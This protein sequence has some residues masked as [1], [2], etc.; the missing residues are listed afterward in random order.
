MLT[1]R[2]CHD[3][4]GVVN[5]AHEI[6]E[7]PRSLSS[8]QSILSNIA[9]MDNDEIIPTITTS[10]TKTS[11]NSKDDNLYAP[12]QKNGNNACDRAESLQNISL[13]C[14]EEAYW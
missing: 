12:Q 9:D 7:C 13:N 4:Y 3:G 6:Q 8:T 5:H 2:N 10:P 14:D 1:N 11:I